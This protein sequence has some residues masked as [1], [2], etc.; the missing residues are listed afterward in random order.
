MQL[1]I[2]KGLTLILT[3]TDRDSV[4]NIGLSDKDSSWTGVAFSKDLGTTGNPYK[5]I[6]NLY[7][8]QR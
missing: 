3:I 5:G 6:I 1:L 8:F 2:A 7:G 4:I